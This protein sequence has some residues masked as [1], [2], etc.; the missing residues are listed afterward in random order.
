MVLIMP[1]IYGLL[2]NDP[3]L[4]DYTLGIALAGV[5][6]WT[7]L[8]TVL[9]YGM[10]YLTANHRLLAY[11]N[12]AILPIYILHQPVILIIGF[13]VILQPLSILAKYL[14]IAPLAFALTLGIYEFGIRRGN[15]ARRLVGLK[16][17]SR[18]TPAAEPAAHPLS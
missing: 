10:N 17:R 1:S 9:G 6:L 14:I 13:F 5:L 16:P 18:M 11:A 2:E 15:P 4:L 8:L 12:E 7:C 3:S